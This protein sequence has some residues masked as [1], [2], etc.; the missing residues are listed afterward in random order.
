[1][2]TPL[3][4]IL[5]EFGLSGSDSCEWAAC[6]RASSCLPVH[7]SLPLFRQEEKFQSV[8]VARIQS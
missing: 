2:P 6:S 5:L 8:G 1:M 3:S 4:D 7:C